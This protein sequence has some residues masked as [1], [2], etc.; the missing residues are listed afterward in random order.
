MKTPLPTQNADPDLMEVSTSSQVWQEYRHGPLGRTTLDDEIV[1]ENIAW[2]VCQM[3]NMK[4]NITMFCWRSAVS[5][6]CAFHERRAHVTK[7]EWETPR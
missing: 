4:K 5:L 1:A 2:Q 7:I 6:P 3:P